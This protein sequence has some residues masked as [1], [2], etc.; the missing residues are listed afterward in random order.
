MILMRNALAALVFA[1]LGATG[2]HALEV[3]DQAPD[4][5]LR[6]SDGETYTLSDFRGEQAVVLAWF[7]KAF[8]RGC[9]IECKSLAE[10]GHLIRRYDVSYF[11]ASVDPLEDNKGFAA[12]TRADFPL[13]SDPDT[14]VARAYGVLHPL[15]YAKR[16]TFYIG[17]DGTILK[18]DTDVK[19]ASSAEDMAATLGELGVALDER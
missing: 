16:H 2:A 6:G 9:T 15:G 7:P 13:L 3:G 18:I 17:K 12:E 10:K 1:L 19:P 4:F 14:T 11:M 5:T 8:T